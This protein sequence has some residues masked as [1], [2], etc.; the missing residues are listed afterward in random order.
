MTGLHRVFLDNLSANTVKQPSLSLF[1][2]CIINIR[3]CLSNYSVK[4]PNISSV[5]EQ[6]KILRYY[7]TSLTF[8][9]SG[10]FPW[11][12]FSKRSVLSDLKRCLHRYEWPKA[13]F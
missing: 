11:P 4:Q 12:E 1:S 10:Y 9:F 2:H 13:L 6:N 3:L 8:L 5:N 7:N